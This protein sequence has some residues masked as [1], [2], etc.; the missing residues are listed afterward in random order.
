MRGRGAGLVALHRGGNDQAARSLGAAH[1]RADAIGPALVLAQVK[2][3]PREEVVAQHFVGKIKRL[4][5]L[6][7]ARK[8]QDPSGHDH[9]LGRARPVDQDDARTRRRD[10]GVERLD[11]AGAGRCLPV[12]QR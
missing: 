6:L 4:Q 10:R 1:G 2:V 3:E 11:R 7:A 8:R 12:A 9:R 5:T